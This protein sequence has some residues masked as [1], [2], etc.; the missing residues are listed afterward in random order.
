MEAPGSEKKEKKEERS[1]RI[2]RSNLEA[3]ESR[4]HRLDG[5]RRT[6]THR[7]GQVSVKLKEGN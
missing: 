3:E 4:T 1:V 2:F 6:M 7:G 5:T